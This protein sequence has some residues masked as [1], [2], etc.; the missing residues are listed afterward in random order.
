MAD[1][2]MEWECL[3]I[4]EMGYSKNDEHMSKNKTKQNTGASLNEL[5]LVETERQSKHQNR[6]G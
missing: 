3:I 6:N 2:R 4:Q 1:S 5:G